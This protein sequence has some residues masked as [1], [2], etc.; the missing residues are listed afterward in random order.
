[1][2]S[3]DKE[4][5]V[6]GVLATNEGVEKLKNAKANQRNS[7]GKPWTYAD[8]AAPAGLDEKTVRRFLRQ[9]QPVDESSARAIC[10]ALSI[11]ANE[12][13]NF[14][15]RYEQDRNGQLDNNHSAFSI[16][17][18]FE[19][20]KINVAKLKAIE[21]S[22]REITGDASLKIID[23]EEGSIRLILEGSQEGLERLE[24]LF[25]SGELTE[26]LDIPVEDVNFVDTG[27]SK[28]DKKQLAFTIADNATSADIENLKAAF[29]K[30][31]EPRSTSI[32]KNPITIKQF[33]ANL[34]SGNIV[35]AFRIF[36]NLSGTDLSG[37]DLRSANLSGADISGA[38]LYSANLSGAD[39]SGADLRSANLSGADLSG[40]NLYSANLSGADLSDAD[41]SGAN[42]INADLSGAN[43]YSAN[44]YSANLN[45]TI[46]DLE[47][48]LDNKWRLVWEIVNQ[49]AEVRDLSGADLS[50]TDLSDANLRSAN[51]INANLSGAFLINAD[52]INAD[53]SSAF[54][55]GANLSGAFL[56]G[57]NL[58]NANL[59]NANLSGAFLSGANL[60]N[61]NLIN[62]N[63]SGA[64]LSGANLINS[65]LINSNLINANLIDAN[66]SGTNLSGAFLSGA[67]LINANLSG[68]DLRSAKVK[69]T[70]FGYNQ[71]ISEELRLDLIQRGAIFEDTPGDRSA[72]IIPR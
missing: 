11:N 27:T 37:A 13:I 71:G 20:N 10:E 6:R 69:N 52:L 59:I 14:E 43:L 28:D 38:N 35:G 33:L 58:I 42:L 61:A 48:K 49:G 34:L 31:S 7:N 55:S 15:S 40:A 39:L 23:I 24:Q 32:R 50:G 12:V 29:I 5:R 36:R 30:N 41:L 2:H 22:L 4:T 25:K 9:E 44:L 46:I 45:G 21:A 72:V 67:N 16:T 3:K 19:K 63:L 26:V 56:S 54:L 60:I 18:S 70:R 62:A 1:M 64:F 51:L 53:L 68:A 17:G 8:I 65:N 47:T 57:A 66:L